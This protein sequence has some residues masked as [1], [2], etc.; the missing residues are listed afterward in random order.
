MKSIGHVGLILLLGVFLFNGCE[1]TRSITGSFSSSVDEELY[2]QVPT[3]KRAGVE[4]AEFDLQIAQEE[5]QLA[6]M[7]KELTSF[8]EIHAKYVKEAADEYRKEA[9]VGVDLAKWEAIDKSGL[10]NKDKN[11]D[12]IADLKAKKFRIKA[13]RVKIEAKRDNV[14]R[15]IKDLSEQIEEQETKIT[16]LK[17]GRK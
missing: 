16:N 17:A 15:Q 11:T 9:E 7:Q 2:G 5:L 6:E 14:E 3:E 4:E 12:I 13:D 10:G 8:Q 1:T